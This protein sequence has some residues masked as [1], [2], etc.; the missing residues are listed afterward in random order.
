MHDR[1]AFVPDADLFFSF[2]ITSSRAQ[3]AA[4]AVRHG[5]AGG[6]TR[7]PADSNRDRPNVYTDCPSFSRPSSP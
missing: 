6:S 2:G 4:G 3:F 5:S 1:H 7:H